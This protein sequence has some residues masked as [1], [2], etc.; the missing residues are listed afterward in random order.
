VDGKNSRPT[1]RHKAATN[2]AQTHLF[3]KLRRVGWVGEWTTCR[4]VPSK[5]YKTSIM[6]GGRLVGMRYHCGMNSCPMFVESWWNWHPPVGVFIGIL[7][8]VGVLVPWF[9]GEKVHLR[10]RMWWS[11]LMIA[12]FALELRTIYLDQS[13]HDHEQQQSRCEETAKF[14]A[15]IEQGR[16]T[17]ER[18]KEEQKEQEQKFAALLKQGG[19]SIKDL[20]GVASKVSEGTSFANGGD[21]YP[22]IFP[23][24]L[25]TEDGRQRV[26]FGLS[27][28]GKYPLFDLMVSV[29]RPYSVSKENNQEETFGAS[30][31]F[32]EMN[33]NWNFPLLAASMDGES[34]A[35]FE[36]SMFARNGKWEEVIDVRRVD[37]KLVSRWVIFQTTD[38][39]GPHSKVLLDLA[40]HAFPPEHRRDT[41]QPFPNDSLP[42][43]EI[44]QQKKAIP[45]L[46]LRPK[47]CAGFW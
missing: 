1:H 4:I 39:S 46:I 40:D 13:Q 25:T 24:Q 33:A 16:A 14:E 38:F 47:Q 11:I 44:S 19:R 32:P 5:R 3:A 45:D 2:G 34:S 21:T 37:G 7:A 30:C 23:Y 31:K 35:Y 26:P 10:E 41:L 8:V 42:L 12:C 9:K 36:A 20:E 18:Q 43:P 28:Q 17:N 22:S 29:G 6:L 15:V 27:K